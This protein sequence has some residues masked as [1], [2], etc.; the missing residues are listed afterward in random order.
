MSIAFH[1]NVVAILQKYTHKIS[2][3]S[4]AFFD[5]IEYALPLLY[6][7]LVRHK[8]IIELLDKSELLFKKHQA[9]IMKL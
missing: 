6:R 3:S 2:N 1:K 5:P 9:V 8:H 7:S 4:S